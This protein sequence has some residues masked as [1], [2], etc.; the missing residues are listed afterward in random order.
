MK[1]FL[2]SLVLSL[3]AFSSSYASCP[4]YAN[5]FSI[6]SQPVLADAAVR[7]DLQ[8]LHRYITLSNDGFSVTVEHTG[9][10]SIALVATG[11]LGESGTQVVGPWSVGLYQN[12]SLVPGSVAAAHNGTDADDNLITLT[13][14]SNVIV[15]AVK[16]DVFQVRNTTFSEI[17][18][19]G[20]ISGGAPQNTSVSIN[21]HQ[22]R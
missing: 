16:G 18:L 1:K 7:F 6:S 10:Y 11:S 20:T 17:E 13:T 8:N 22:I 21:F 5:F 3:A 4:A 12:G 14:T 15:R 2:F 19:I 9:N